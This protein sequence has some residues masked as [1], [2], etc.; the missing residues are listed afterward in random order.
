MYGLKNR[1]VVMSVEDINEFATWAADGNVHKM[2]RGYRVQ[3]AGHFA[4]LVEVQN[5]FMKEFIAEC[6]EDL[7]F[8]DRRDWYGE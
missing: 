6:V 1:V 3:G 7:R 4:T 8:E 2:E 5:Y